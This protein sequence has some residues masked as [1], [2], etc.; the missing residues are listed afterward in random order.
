MFFT[1]R[2]VEKLKLLSFESKG[3]Y[4]SKLNIFRFKEFGNNPNLQ[5]FSGVLKRLDED[6]FYAHTHVGGIYPNPSSTDFKSAEKINR[7]LSKI[8]EKLVFVM[9]NVHSVS[10]TKERNKFFVVCDIVFYDGETVI[11]RKNSQNVLFIKE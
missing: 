9:L 7:I 2:R 6:E 8:D 1:R 3:V 10:L 11:A 4:D 5:T